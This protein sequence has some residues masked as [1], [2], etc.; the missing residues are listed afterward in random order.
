MIRHL[1]ASKK[2]AS[3]ILVIML[4]VVLVVFGVAAL[5]TAL[6]SLRLTQ[7]VTDWNVQYYGAEAAA[8][9][10]CAQID[11]AVQAALTE[12]GADETS[13]EAALAALDFD[14]QAEETQDGLRI[15]YK[16]WSNDGTVGIDAVLEL[17]ISDATLQVVQ[18]Q[19]IQQEGKA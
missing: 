16:V 18:W 10:R 14:I 3:S 19:E 2:G 5:T 8:W 17:D 15:G 6:S 9:E 11:R 12:P 4:L 1:L 13:P 7:K